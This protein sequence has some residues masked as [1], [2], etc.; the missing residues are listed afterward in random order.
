MVGCAHV[1]IRWVVGCPLRPFSF[2]FLLFLSLSLALSLSLSLSLPL[3]LSLSLSRFR[4]R[5]A[6]AT[7]SQP[8]ESDT[9]WTII[10]SATAFRWSG[11]WVNRRS[12]LW[13]ICCRL[14]LA[15][16]VGAPDRSSFLPGDEFCWL[17]GYG[18]YA[19]GC[20]LVSSLLESQLCKA[21]FE[22]SSI[23]MFL[24]VSV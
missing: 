10:Q 14:L 3:S 1:C 16:S 15:V 11:G 21:W 23:S 20:C 4:P 18:L 8:N 5:W 22:C 24:F 19:V 6:S 13:A 17:L 2:S 9:R 7:Q 12:G